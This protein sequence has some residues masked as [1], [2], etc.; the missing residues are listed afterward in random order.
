MK[1][2][3]FW[4]ALHE[5]EPGA[6]YVSISRQIQKGAENIPQYPALFPSWDIIRLAHDGNYDDAS[7]R[8]YRDRYYR[9]LD[10]L[11]AQKVYD[12]LSDA[13][14][15]C[16]ESPRDLASGRKY[17]HRRMVAGWLEEQLGIVVP[18]GV[19]RKDAGLVVPAVYRTGEFVTSV[20]K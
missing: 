10:T 16:Y 7:F 18:E 17:C 5:P 3:Y 9:M 14:I 2:G 8:A 4:K 19:R 15:I 12:D 6:R 13:V 11:D 1:T 20:G